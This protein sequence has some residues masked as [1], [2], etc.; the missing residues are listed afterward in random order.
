MIGLCVGATE[1][2]KSRSRLIWY[3]CVYGVVASYVFLHWGDFVQEGASVGNVTLFG[4]F[5]VLTALP[6]LESFQIGQVGGNV[7]SPFESL[8][9]KKQE[10]DNI[11][12]E[13]SD[14]MTK[15]K[16]DQKELMKEIE[17]VA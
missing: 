1:W 12:K 10:I 7:C 14:N 4:F 5:L 9:A 3:I 17:R 8:A 16:K 15:A 13:P 6:F 2:A 11:P